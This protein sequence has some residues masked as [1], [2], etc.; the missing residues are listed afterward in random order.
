MEHEFRKLVAWLRKSPDKQYVF[1]SPTNCLVAHYLKANYDDKSPPPRFDGGNWSSIFPGI[2]YMDRLMTYH[3]IG[4]AKPYT[5]KAALKRAED[6][7]A[8]W[9][10]A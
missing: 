7:A 2:E 6:E 10:F 8:K 3:R 5:Y 9:S 1:D 4:D